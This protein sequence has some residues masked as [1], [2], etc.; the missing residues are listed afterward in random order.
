M[1]DIISIVV[2]VYNVAYLLERCI[3][4]ILNQTY[5]NLEII[6]VDDGSTDESGKLCDYYSKKD[7]PNII[8][9][10]YLDILI[11]LIFYREWTLFGLTSTDHA[12]SINLTTILKSQRS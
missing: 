1:N 12:L 3:K 6:L 5:K 9:N 4:S 10:M 2:P 7:S 11:H 8:E